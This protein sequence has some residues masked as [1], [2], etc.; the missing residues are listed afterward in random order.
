MSILKH[1]QRH[2]RQSR[3]LLPQAT[4]IR[5]SR[6]AAAARAELNKTLP[7]YRKKLG[8]AR[9][10]MAWQIAFGVNSL[11]VLVVIPVSIVYVTDAEFKKK[12]I[13]YFYN[14]RKIEQKNHDFAKIMAD[15]REDIRL[16]NLDKE[17][18]R[19]MIKALEN[20]DRPEIAT[21]VV[22]K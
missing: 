15:A 12:Y 5:M 11:L 22:S 10:E 7:W 2:Q 6:A 19:A 18:R 16:M 21:S 3:N 14:V 8:Q 4:N 9:G 17:Q 13:P 1:N 20:P